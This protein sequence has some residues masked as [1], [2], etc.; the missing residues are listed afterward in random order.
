MK[1]I[2]WE[3]FKA[4]VVLACILA[5]FAFAVPIPLDD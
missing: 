1:T 2:A 3:A 4:V 5:G